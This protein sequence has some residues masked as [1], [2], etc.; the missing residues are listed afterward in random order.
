M[1]CEWTYY[2]IELPQFKLSYIRIDNLNPS[3]V[4]KLLNSTQWEL[5][6]NMIFYI[7]YLFEKINIWRIKVL[8]ELPHKNTYK[9]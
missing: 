1:A 8:R 4:V 2:R 3:N 9:F 5:K 6:A 7:L